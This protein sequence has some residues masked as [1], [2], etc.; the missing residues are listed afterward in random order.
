M[1]I[2]LIVPRRLPAFQR[3]A[4]CWWLPSLVPAGSNSCGEGKLKEP[5]THALFAHAFHY[6]FQEFL[7][8]VFFPYV[9]LDGDSMKSQLCIFYCTLAYVLTL[10]LFKLVLL[11]AMLYHGWWH[12][13]HVE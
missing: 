9:S 2:A 13:I 11:C 4:K 5:G 12:Q 1:P 10:V 6:F 7:E 3:L 8:I